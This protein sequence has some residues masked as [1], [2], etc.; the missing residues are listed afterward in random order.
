MNKTNG[1]YV[2]CAALCAALLGCADYDFRKA[3]RL[4]SKGK[5]AEAARAFERFLEKH[6]DDPRVPE[7]A[8][9]AGKIHADKFDLCR[10]AVPLFEK[11]A[12]FAGKGAAASS[13]TAVSP[14][15][16]RARLALLSCPDYFPA[17]P[18]GRWE[19][20]DTLSGGQ[21]M[22]LE[23]EVR[24]STDTAGTELAGSYFAGEEKFREYRRVCG[25]E[26]W[27]LWEEESGG[28]IPVLRFPFRK[29]HAWEAV[30]KGERVRFLIEEDAASVKVKAGTFSDCLKVKQHHAGFESWTYDYFCPNVGR[31]KTTVGV[32][33][34]ENPN[35]ELASYKLK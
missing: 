3:V 11:A 4:E 33:G 19:Y 26:G 24:G 1:S 20:V 22:R 15:P 25:R 8:Y 17:P 27:S 16:E 10:Q 23:V 29:G 32:P 35:T 21:N 12:R 34:A 7:A 31:V 6:P 9:L 18:G 5:V 13:G 14:W 2:L 28:R 30:L